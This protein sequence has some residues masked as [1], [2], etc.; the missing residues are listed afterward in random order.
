M[1]IVNEILERE[2]KKAEKYKPITVEK[3]LEL[4][5]DIGSLLASDTND[6][7]SKLLKSDKER[8]TYLQSLSRDN[9]QLLLN[10]IWEL[11]TERIEEAI[12]VRLPHPTTVLPRAKP[13]PKP[14]PL[15]KWQEF[16]KAK[17]ITKKKKDKLKW[18]EELQK[19][20]PLFG[21][22]KAAAEKEKNW[23]IEV[24]Q[25][26]DPM[27]DMYEKKASE[28]SEKVAKNELQRLKN[29]ARARKVKIPRVGLPVTSDKAS[30]TQL[31]TAATIAKA[32]T[33]SL[34]KFQ[35]KLPKEKEARGK[36]IHE[37]IPGKERKRKAPIPTPKAE[38][39]A[40]L[41]LLDNILNKRP[42]IDME[43][44]VTKR[45]NDEQVQRSEEKKATNPKTGKRK[46]KGG[47]ATKFS[48]KKPKAGKGQ[49]NPGKKTGGRKRR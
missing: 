37:L 40:N 29:I 47:N 16:A 10:K 11:P 22:K 41:S 14:K 12:V 18:D 42:K 19:W 8:D 2:Q 7:E 39:E 46:G 36:G 13:V 5:F 43:K 34:G 30:A 20:V 27:T 26:V 25:N 38:R 21:F 1:D 49:R 4:E 45:I 33:A 44:A 24:P 9:T 23:L 28:K 17:G 15:T 32:S 6:L 31:A 48:A 3:H 35:D